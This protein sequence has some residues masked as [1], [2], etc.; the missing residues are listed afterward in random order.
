[1]RNATLLA[2]FLSALALSG[3]VY[4]TLFL[5]TVNPQT[6]QPAALDVDGRHV[7]FTWTDDNTNENL[8]IYTDKA[9]YT[10]GISSAEMYVAVANKSTQNQAVSLMGFFRDQTQSVGKV[11]VLT[12]ITK[13]TK[14]PVY[15]KTCPTSTSTKCTESL[16][17]E[18]VAQTKEKKWIE[19]PQLTRAVADSITEQ[20]KLTVTRKD[21][22]G[23]VA[24]R[25]TTEFEIA[26]NEVA[27]FKVLVQFPA[28]TSDNFYL[29]ALGSQGGYGH[30]DPWFD[31]NYQYRVRLDINPGMVTG[32][33][34]LVNFPVY[35]ALQDLP[36]HFHTNV[37]TDGCDIRVVKADEITETPFELVNYNSG[38]DTGELH[39]KADSLNPTLAT[40]FYIYYG[41]AAATC[42]AVTDTY[43]R[44]NVWTAYDVVLH[45]NALTDSTGK[46][47]IGQTGT[48]AYGTGKLGNGFSI[49]NTANYPTA[50]DAADL[51]YT[52][53]MYFSTWA[54]SPLLTRTHFVSKESWTVTTGYWL[55][56]D[57]TAG[58][59]FMGRPGV[60][61]ANDRISEAQF[62][63]SLTHV[64]FKKT[65]ATNVKVYFNGALNKTTTTNVT[66][67]FGV[68]ATA[69]R[70]GA[71]TDT[72]EYW[73]GILDEVR[74]SATLP[75]DDWITTEYNNQNTPKLFYNINPTPVKHVI[76]GGKQ[77]VRGGTLNIK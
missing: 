62:M 10:N 52:G 42:Y 15:T 30:L 73:N 5:G 75:S 16:I 60:S 59:F 63:T 68:N 58:Q 23:F 6:G 20:Q 41:Y 32:A 7:E 61:F 67:A 72:A 40:T 48:V 33:T 51:D 14:T 29:E 57:G 37:K 2:S 11:S 56:M 74:M 31:A 3:V 19:L 24:Q 66:A 34:A 8:I 53:N 77:T 28:N 17:R 22:E 36:A 71:R 35:V 21:S 49:P 69:V 54:S 18:D 47:T 64:V 44:N 76:K 13:E 46:R 38:A 12:E 45:S 55:Y 26:P 27:Y 1:M 39:F 43:G 9:T 65:A 4:V 50:P 70:F 25:K